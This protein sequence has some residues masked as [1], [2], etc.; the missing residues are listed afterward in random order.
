MILKSLYYILYW[1]RSE[2]DRS[3]SVSAKYVIH[4]AADIQG[5]GIAGTVATDQQEIPI[6]QAGSRVAG[7]ERWL[8]GWAAVI[9][10]ANRMS[11]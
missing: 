4:M 8:M 11:Q 9:S 1:E 7:S 10:V 5:D 3:Q 6:P 2:V